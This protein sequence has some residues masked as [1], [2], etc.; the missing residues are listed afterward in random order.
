MNKVVYRIIDVIVATDESAGAIYV[1]AHNNGINI[2]QQKG[3][4]MQQIIDFYNRPIKRS[5]KKNEP[6]MAAVSEIMK[7]LAV[8]SGDLQEEN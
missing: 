3:L 4:T 6:D 7:A 8:A 5:R 1:W 2:R